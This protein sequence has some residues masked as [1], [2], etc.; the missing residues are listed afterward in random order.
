MIVPDNIIDASTK[1]LEE[2]QS[3][4]KNGL[5]DAL[6]DQKELVLN[7]TKYNGFYSTIYSSKKINGSSIINSTKINYIIPS[8]NFSTQKNKTNVS[9]SFSDIQ[10]NPSPPKNLQRN[11]IIQSFGNPKLTKILKNLLKNEATSENI[12][13]ILEELK[14][15][16]RVIMKN[17]NGSSFCCDLFQVCDKN[18][19]L[20]I[21][22]EISKNISE[23]SVNRY[24]APAIQALIKLSSSEEEYQLILYS[25]DKC[26]LLFD[27]IDKNASI[28]IQE[29]IQHIPESSRKTFDL[30]YLEIFCFISK[31]Q[32]GVINAKLFCSTIKNEETI[33]RIVSLIVN[34]FKELINNEFS[35]N[36]VKHV[37]H[38]WGNKSYG[39]L[40]KNL[41]FYNF[42][43][44][45]SKNS[46][47]DLC[48]S[49]L[50]I[51]SNEDK[52]NLITKLKLELTNSND[53]TLSNYIIQQI[54]GTSNENISNKNMN[55]NMNNNCM[56]Q[57]SCLTNTISN[58]QNQRT[59]RTN[60]PRVSVQFP[61]SL[62]KSNNNT[63]S[64]NQNQ[65]INI[66]SNNSSKNSK[67]SDI[68]TQPPL[69]N[70]SFNAHDNKNPK[71]KN[72]EQ[73]NN[74]NSY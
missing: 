42:R 30:L 16:F 69:I 47:R 14:G 60:Q 52:N 64:L 41:I 51:A 29:I 73:N 34:D 5:E 33:K 20:I 53:R 17:K 68:N 26:N 67:N 25:F 55:I 10:K 45:Y 31:K 12:Y 39:R 44:I 1:N 35:I 22:K 27:C 4:K 3:I 70:K 2:Q 13:S 28:V 7:T 18:Q 59:I 49:F 63:N 72:N 36:L 8:Q 74:P 32:T 40:L 54:N 56:N 11:F 37:L 65:Y 23:D 15:C 50:K 71:E 48:D 9:S 38:L 62:Q 46:L 21:L 43:A 61:M 57:F 58:V 66:P 6:K 24:S 19:R